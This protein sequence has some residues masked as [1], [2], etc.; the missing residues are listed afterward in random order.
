MKTTFF[1]QEFREK[2]STLLGPQA[3]A[4]FSACATK[5]GKSVW[6]NSL[7]IAPGEL[8]GKM[9][10][11]GW[12]LEPLVFHEN[13]FA[14][15]GGPSDRPGLSEEFQAGLFNL[16]EKASMLPALA[17]EP[18]SGE[19]VLDAFAAPGNKTLQL[20]CLAGNSAEIIALERER[21]R[22]RA[23]AFNVRKF[24][25]SAEAKLLD[26]QKFKDREGFDRILLDAPCSSEGLVRKRFDGLSGW[27]QKRVL[28]MA[29]RQKKAVAKGF[30]LLREGGRMVYSTCSLSPEE[31]EEV[32]E[33]L[34]EKRPDA[35][36][37]KIGLEGVA[38][39]TALTEHGEK[40][41]HDEV[42]NCSRFYP[43]V[44]DCQPFFIALI[45]KG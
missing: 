31:D 18:K 44:W 16:Q 42:A 43:H 29:K 23:L 28:N 14:L 11:Q 17:L 38:A 45:R 15:V 20:A 3:E 6:C 22:M 10:K 32:V 8:R 35:K 2:Y 33:F 40:R 27:S 26:F 24:G 21:P 30:E 41:F 5:E 19:R 37:E 7:A 39:S 13:A 4:F 25:I 34:L 1:P 36:V 12:K 9:E